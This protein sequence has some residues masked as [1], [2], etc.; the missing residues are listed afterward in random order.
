MQRNFWTYLALILVGFGALGAFNKYFISGEHA[1][2]IS[3][4]VPWGA[5]IAAY[6][7]F[8]VSATGTGLVASLA[9]LLNKKI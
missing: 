3:P 9:C 6:V 2:G 5:L 8:A 7:F 1:F 4:E